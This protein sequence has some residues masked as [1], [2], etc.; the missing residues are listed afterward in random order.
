MRHWLLVLCFLTLVVSACGGASTPSAAVAFTWHN[1]ETGQS[2]SAAD[3][4]YF[5]A[6]GYTATVTASAGGHAVPLAAKPE[7]TA[8][9]FQAITVTPGTPASEQDITD[10]SKGVCTVDLS[11][12]GHSAS[13]R[14]YGE[15]SPPP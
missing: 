7:N 8:N 13:L 3:I 14:V 5:T 1:V 6:G 15:V 11:A 9:C 12:A 10:D 4:L 2:G